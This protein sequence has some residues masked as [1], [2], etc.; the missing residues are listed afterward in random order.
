MHLA[1]YLGEVSQYFW[2]LVTTLPAAYVDDDVTVGVLGQGLRDD[3][4]STTEGSGDGC[5]SSLHTSSRKREARVKKW[6]QYR[7]SAAGWNIFR[8]L[9]GKER[10]ALSVR[11]AAGDWRAA[12]PWLVALVWRATPEPLWTSP[13]PPQTPAPSPHPETETHGLN[14]KRRLTDTSAVARGLAHSRWRRS[15]QVEPRRSQFLCFW[16]AA[17]SCA[18]WGSSRA[19]CRRCRLLWCDCQPNSD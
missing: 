9:T 16:E 14:T 11:S 17:W 5:G 3:G 13:S 1:T 6:L 19:P 18:W 15:F 12:S 8:R 7:K 10:P 2:H 4:L